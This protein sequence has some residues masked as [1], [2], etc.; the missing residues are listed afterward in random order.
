MALVFGLGFVAGALGAPIRSSYPARTTADEPNYLL[1]ALSLAEDR[2]LDISDEQRN[3]RYLPFHEVPLRPQARVQE[4][5]RM[6][7]PHDPLLP[8]LLALPLALGGWLAA[9]LTLAGM[10]GALAALVL[11][12]AVRR[13]EV[14]LMSA[15]VVTAV[16]GLSAPL[17]IY[18]SQIYP[19]MPAALALGVAIACITGPL[20]RRGMA[21]FIPAIVALAWLG[22]K[23]IPVA[24]VLAALG[25]LRLVR[26]DRL[27]D[28]L[29]V[30]GTFLVAGLAYL[31]AHLRWYGGLTVYASSAYFVRTGQFSVMGVRPNY[32]AR[33][34]RLIGLLV[35]KRFGLAAWQPAWLLMVPAVG[36]LAGK[37]PK[38]WQTL[39]LPL[40]AGW[41]AATFLALTMH[42]WWW[43]GRQTVV[44]LPAAVLAITVW[45]GPSRRRLGITAGLAAAGMLSL[46]WIYVEGWRGRI[47]LVVDFFN[48]SNPV[49][50]L[51]ALMLPNYAAPSFG[52]WVLHAGWTALALG[53]FLSA[54][55]RAARHSGDTGADRPRPG[56]F[57]R[58]R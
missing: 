13:F 53:A 56:R 45:V 41:L 46:A 29:V 33:S 22:T 14:P 16:F 37:R 54:L 43:P 38:H 20:G 27:Q 21:G 36:F 3:R 18:G 28:A 55:T 5:G 25:L 2:S 4:G 1:T 39:V 50:R 58:A 42:G 7:S 17:A 35:D 34:V 52:D 6:V 11:W 31:V 32:P 10:A 30:A 51:W 49:Y 57:A 8:A 40:L 15:T 12:I 44:V 47:A 48:T 24:S 19:E 9:K 26:Q 23:F